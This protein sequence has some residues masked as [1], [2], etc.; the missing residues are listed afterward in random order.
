MPLTM[1]CGIGFGLVQVPNNRN[2]FLPAPREG[3]GAAGGMQGTARLAGQTA[4]GVVMSLLFTVASVESAPRV[5]LGIGA[6]LT[7]R[8]GLVSVLRVQPL[9]ETRT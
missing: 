4:G 6:V 2:M 9:Q 3:A 5:G 8:A 1:L 7:L